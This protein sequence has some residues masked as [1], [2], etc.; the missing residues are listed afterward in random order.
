MWP[1]NVKPATG[2]D[3]PARHRQSVQTVEDPCANEASRTDICRGAEGARSISSV[4]LPAVPIGDTAFP[5]GSRTEAGAER[6]AP[7]AHECLVR[8]GAWMP[9]VHAAEQAGGHA[10]SAA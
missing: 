4:H 6:T 2:Q 9:F 5:P 10:R 1:S 7:H 3:P 8:L